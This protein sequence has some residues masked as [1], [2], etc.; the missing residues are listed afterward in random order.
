MG[1][2]SESFPSLTRPVN[3]VRPVQIFS[4]VEVGTEFGLQDA[5]CL[6][7]PGTSHGG[8]R[9]SLA[10]APHRSLVASVKKTVCDYTWWRR[11]E[12]TGAGLPD[13]VV[14]EGSK[15]DGSAEMRALAKEHL[16]LVASA[17]LTAIVALKVFAFSRYNVETAAAVVQVAGTGN[18]V[19][20]TL[21]AMLPTLVMFGL[22]EVLIRRLAWL[23][24]LAP[25]ERRAV[26]ASSALPLLMLFLFV[27]F[28]T[29]LLYLTV[30]IAVPLVL[31]WFVRWH[32]RK[33]SN[34]SPVEPMS[35]VERTA[36]RAAF[37]LYVFF[38]VVTATWLPS[39]SV[40]VDG[41]QPVKAYVVGV[42]DGE[43]VFLPAGN[44]GLVAA[45]TSDVRRRYCED[46]SWMT[47][48]LVGLI[49]GRNY[50]ECP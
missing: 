29:A 23:R 33:R 37:P 22:G 42:R 13:S 34:P 3:L 17:G 43:T 12:M 30:V 18:V 28:V 47:S 49:A 26:L 9:D 41:G 25:L 5:N 40:A 10:T 11:V 39:E 50:P 27:P 16:A 31:G 24:R 7:L 36:A 38:T 6:D 19:V 21:V 2:L 32:D 1:A 8:R 14:V 48:T 44:H 46:A 45:P 20:G 15:T 35:D 4:P